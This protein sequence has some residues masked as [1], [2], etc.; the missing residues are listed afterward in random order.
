MSRAPASAGWSQ[1][2]AVAIQAQPQQAPTIWASSSSEPPRGEAPPTSS[3]R[4]LAVD[5]PP[6]AS[7]GKGAGA[8]GGSGWDRC[9][10][11]W[12]ERRVDGWQ[13]A[14]YTHLVQSRTRPSP[15]PLAQEHGKLA[16]H[17]CGPQAPPMRAPLRCMR[18]SDPITMPIE[19]RPP[20]SCRR[21]GRPQWEQ[22]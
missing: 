18:S 20:P 22:S 4:W 8:V 14:A 10:L 2:A 7:C 15:R 19:V 21:T 16:C 9:L 5:A 12:P 13:A 1:Q 6:P 17:T 11:A 3:S